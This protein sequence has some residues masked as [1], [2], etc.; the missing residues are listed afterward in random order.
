[1]KLNFSITTALEKCSNDKTCEQNNQV[2][3][4]FKGSYMCDCREGYYFK[5]KQC[6]GKYAFLIGIILK[7]NVCD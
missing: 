1:M 2:C 3:K 7:K 4:D 6:V 5:A